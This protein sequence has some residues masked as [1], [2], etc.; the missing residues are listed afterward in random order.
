MPQ[1]EPGDP[2]RED[3]ARPEFADAVGA[4]VIAAER[5]E[6]TRPRRG[7]RD[8]R[9]T[10]GVLEV[11]RVLVGRPEEEL[12]GRPRP[13]DVGSTWGAS[14]PRRGLRRRELYAY[15][16]C[17]RDRT[18][19]SR[20]RTPAGWSPN[21]PASGSTGS[22]YV[23]GTGYDG[24]TF[25]CRQGDHRDRVATAAAPTSW[26]A[27]RSG[28]S[29]TWAARTGKAIHVDEPRQGHELPHERQCAA[30]TGRGMEV[31]ADLLEVRSRS[32][33]RGRSR[34]T[35]NP[36]GVRRR[37]VFAKSGGDGQASRRVGARTA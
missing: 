2:G 28:R 27:R 25:P 10:H 31:I 17:A 7:V 30:G 6:L 13:H 1:G 36:V 12:E 15:A 37:V 35:R 26:R 19:P 4:A 11:E 21:S 8:V 20:P 5:G 32:S 9:R 14:A 3:P 24:S 34:S 23:V 29:S 33:A 22:R 16:S 18:R